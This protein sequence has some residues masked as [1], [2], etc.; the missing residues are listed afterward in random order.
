MAD[1]FDEINE[2]LK[3]DRMAALWQ[4][5][6]K[7]LIA[8]VV[9]IVAGVSLSQGYSYYTTQRDARAA[10]A[11]FQAILAD[12]VTS[13]LETAAP[14][15]NEGYA[16]LA[17]FRSAAALAQDGKAAEAE[18]RYLALAE[19]TDAEQIY[20]DLALLLSVMHAPQ[21]A[22][23]ADLQARLEPLASASSSLQGLAL[24]QMVA[25]D[26]QRG[27]SAAAIEKLNRLVA[28]TDIP[29]SLRQRAAQIL[30][31]VSEGQ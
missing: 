11:F 12:D 15:L 7:Y 22:D 28:L 24:E 31:V 21:T 20:R 2:E 10:D 6:G 5:Y 4:R 16:L 14:E 13:S 8:V 1:I 27:D 23:A 19:R 18:Q 3:Q 17:E 30:N 29:T 9:A 26:L 25:L